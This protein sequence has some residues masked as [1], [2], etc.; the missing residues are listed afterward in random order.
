MAGGA[1]VGSGNCPSSCSSCPS[2]PRHGQSATASS[3]ATAAPSPWA[4]PAETLKRGP[5]SALDTRDIPSSTMRSGVF[6]L[7]GFLVLRAEPGTAPEEKRGEY[8][9]ANLAGARHRHPGASS[10]HSATPHPVPLPCRPLSLPG[11]CWH[12]LAHAGGDGVPA[13]CSAV[14]QP[15]CLGEPAP[16]LG[17]TDTC[18]CPSRTPPRTPPAPCVPSSHQHTGVLHMAGAL[19]ASPGTPAPTWADLALGCLCPQSPAPGP[20]LRSRL[21]A[22][23][24]LHGEGGSKEGA[25][26]GWQGLCRGAGVHGPSRTCTLALSG[27][28]SSHLPSLPRSC[29][30]LP[31]TEMDPNPSRGAWAPAARAPPL[32][33][34]RW[35]RLCP[36][37]AALPQDTSRV[38]SLF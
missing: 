24:G 35:G 12:C 38:P 6:L 16:T 13:G 9:Q 5:S 21:W 31:T 4:P 14:P 37:A 10:L 25:V 3:L 11:T 7:L 22:E 30:W 23:R 1:P 33:G 17:C 18:V 29:T 27:L 28:C 26:R 19:L 20:A 8:W 36:A 2:C 15:R 32:W 34:R